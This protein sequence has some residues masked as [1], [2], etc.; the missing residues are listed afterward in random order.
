M[1][2]INNYII[3]KL[4]LNKNTEVEKCIVIFN[5]DKKNPDYILYNS[6]EE[7]ANGITERNKSWHTAYILN[8]EKDINDFFDSVYH[9]K[10]GDFDKKC[11][12]SGWKWVGGEISDILKKKNGKTK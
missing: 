1:K 2:T 12:E 5:W 10:K 4:K 11:E 8:S 9:L 6:V 7:A 3:E